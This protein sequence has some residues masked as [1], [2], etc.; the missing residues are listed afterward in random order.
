MLEMND[1]MGDRLSLPSQQI[2]Q[3]IQG[4]SIHGR[5]GVEH[6][7]GSAEGHVK[8]NSVRASQTKYLQNVSLSSS[9]QLNSNPVAPARLPG[10]V[11][12]SQTCMSQM[13]ATNS[14]KH[15]QNVHG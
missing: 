8:N 7:S 13:S 2:S 15:T 1:F 11:H 6:G 9:K 10:Q 12:N 4:Q 14:T 3:I 5:Q